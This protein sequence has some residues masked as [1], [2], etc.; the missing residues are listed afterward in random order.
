MLDT[1]PVPQ[2]SSPADD[3]ARSQQLYQSSQTFLLRMPDP[4]VFWLRAVVIGFILLFFFAAIPGLV[5][6]GAVPD[7]K[8]N[9]LGKYL[10]FAI[11]ALGIDLIWGYTGLLSLCQALFFAMGGYAMA[12]HLSLKQG[13]GDVRPEYNNIPQF[14]FFNNVKEL[15]GFWQPFTSMPASLIAAMFLPGLAAALFGFFI[16]RS[17][18]KGVYFSII[19]QALAWAAFLLMSRNEMLL[20]GTNGLT[21]FYKPMMQERRWIIGLYLLTL[22]GV[23]GA[24]FICRAIVRSRLGR[25]LVAVRDKETRL[26]F[27]G[28]KPYAFKVFAFSVGAMLAAVGGMLYSPQVGIITPQDMNVEASIFMVVGVAV[29]GRGKLWGAVFGALLMNVARSALSSDLPTLWPF[30]LGGVAVTVVL[31]FP[32]GF[33]GIWSKLERQITAGAGIAQAALTAVPLVAIALFVIVEALGLMPFFLEGSFVRVFGL[34]PKYWV[35]VAILASAGATSFAVKRAAQRRQL[36]F[37]VMPAAVP[38]AE[39]V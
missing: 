28:Y 15:P 11:V 19:T 23:C 21:N 22:A 14:M 27:A 36:G 7:Y 33:A 1:P 16:L 5:A 38:A 30:V 18:V 32:E 39:G 13:G 26:Y 20:G 24:Y 37:A 31:F 9:F 25:V 6:A 2:T 3:A 34:P 17:R 4:R 12:M 35:L 10:C 8:L 29:G